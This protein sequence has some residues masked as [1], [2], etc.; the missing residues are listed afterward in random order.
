VLSRRNRDLAGRQGLKI[1]TQPLGKT[2]RP[3]SSLPQIRPAYPFN[4]LKRDAIGG[5]LRMV[6]R[7]FLPGEIEAAKAIRTARA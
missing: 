5:H 7:H 2:A 1:A 3:S 6:A 4:R